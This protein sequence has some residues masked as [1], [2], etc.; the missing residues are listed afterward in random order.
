MEFLK[1]FQPVGF[2]WDQLGGSEVKTEA[3]MKE[4]KFPEWC[5]DQTFKSWKSDYEAYRNQVVGKIVEE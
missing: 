3:P 5:K 2:T 1:Q 4:L